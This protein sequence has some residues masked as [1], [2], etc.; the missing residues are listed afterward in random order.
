MTNST[1]KFPQSVLT[2]VSEFLSAKLNIL[3]KRKQAIAKQDPFKDVSRIDD[4]AAPD[5]EADEQDGHA[6][7]SAIGSEIG[8]AMVQIRKALT[9]IKLGKYGVC[10]V[11]GNMIDTDRLVIYPEATLC[12]KDSRKSEK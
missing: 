10:E 7:T 4:N 6:R 9:M 5:I 3:K 2:P 8:R 12:T 11:C 1:P